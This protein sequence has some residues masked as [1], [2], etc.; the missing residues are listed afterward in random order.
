MIN[1]E[2][3]R[4]KVYQTKGVQGDIPFEIAKRIYLLNGRWEMKAFFTDI[5][6]GKK[7]SA[8]LFVYNPSCCVFPYGI[9]GRSKGEMGTITDFERFKHF[10][11]MPMRFNGLTDREIRKMISDIIEFGK[12]NPNDIIYVYPKS[13]A[14]NWTTPEN[15]KI[16]IISTSEPM[17]NLNWKNRGFINTQLKKMGSPLRILADSDL[18][19]TKYKIK[20]EEE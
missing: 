15:Q 2:K 4:L 10:I 14:R 5:T 13:L 18:I 9:A 1:M 16:W 11:N 3:E 7:V 8:P 12:K 20:Y 17:R 6:T 19:P